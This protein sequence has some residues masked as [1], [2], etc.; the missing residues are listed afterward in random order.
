LETI[1]EILGK[2]E[3]WCW[4]RMEKISWTDRVRNEEMLHTVKEERNITL[5]PWSTVLP[6]KLKCPK[7]LKKFPAFYGTRRF[8]TVYTKA[9]QLSLS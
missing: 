1:S 4:R 8:I 3:M 7:L 5:T 9:R 6:E 2:F